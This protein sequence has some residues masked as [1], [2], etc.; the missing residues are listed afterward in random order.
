MCTYAPSHYLSAHRQG[1]WTKSGLTASPGLH[2]GMDFS[3]KSAGYYVECNIAYYTSEV[4]SRVLTSA[5]TWY[6]VWLISWVFLSHWPFATGIEFWYRDLIQAQ[7]LLEL[8]HHK[9]H[10]CWGSTR[11]LMLS[12]TC[13][14]CF[15]FKAMGPNLCFSVGTERASSSHFLNR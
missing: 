3:V 12:G 11:C 2:S 1:V 7:Y 8:L 6:E 4:I 10:R 14:V 9:K 13:P 15:F 5:E